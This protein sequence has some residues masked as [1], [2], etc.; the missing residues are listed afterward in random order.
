MD[1]L[2]KFDGFILSGM[3]TV[4]TPAVKVIGPAA[5]TSVLSDKLEEGE[6]TD[7]LCQPAQTENNSL[8]GTPIS[9][10]DGSSYSSTSSTRVL[11]PLSALARPPDTSD[12]T[13]WR[14][15]LGRDQ[16]EDEEEVD[17]ERWML[18][19]TEAQQDKSSWGVFLD[20]FEDAV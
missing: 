2:L 18:D 4:K 14:D 15:D 10:T 17:E 7:P 13:A 1:G 19:D 11:L 16:R 3:P 5:H 6:D 12:S 20:E 8:P 9:T